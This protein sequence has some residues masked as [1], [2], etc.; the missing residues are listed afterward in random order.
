MSVSDTVWDHL[1]TGKRYRILDFYINE[2]D[3]VPYVRYREE[4]GSGIFGRACAIFFDGRFV[5]VERDVPPVEGK[6]PY[7][8]QKP[9]EVNWDAL[10]EESPKVGLSVS[11]GYAPED[12][13]INGHRIEDV[14]GTALR[15]GDM[16]R[17]E[18]EQSGFKAHWPHTNPLTPTAILGFNDIGMLWV[19][20]K[21]GLDRTLIDPL[22]VR[23]VKR[24]ANGDSG[25]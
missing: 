18:D 4:E 14:L 20:D 3:L 13:V 5:P 22:A 6:A 1:K 9:L 11:K 10:N 15:H 8:P 19:A 17:L 16:V 2:A 23:F 7:D 25:E 12:Y 24:A 21:T